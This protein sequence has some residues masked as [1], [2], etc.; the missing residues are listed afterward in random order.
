MSAH[1]E[2]R[3]MIPKTERKRCAYV[4]G[5]TLDVRMKRKPLDG[6]WVNHI[7]FVRVSQSWGRSELDGFKP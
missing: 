3:E 2:V 6:V 7:D 5:E 1:S 4:E